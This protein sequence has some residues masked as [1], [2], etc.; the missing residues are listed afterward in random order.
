[1]TWDAEQFSK[2][3]QEQLRQEEPE[4]LPPL[5]RWLG[6]IASIA[7]DVTWS[8]GADIRRSMGRNRRDGGGDDGGWFGGDGG[9]E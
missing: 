5:K 1:M 7:S 6:G 8:I 2:D 3:Y 9:G 4:P